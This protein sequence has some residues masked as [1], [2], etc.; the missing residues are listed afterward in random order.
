MNHEEIT[1]LMRQWFDN[2]NQH[3]DIRSERNEMM[4]TYKCESEGANSTTCIDRLKEQPYSQEDV[5][6]C[7]I[8]AKR[9]SY[10]KRLQKL[11]RTNAGIL[12]KVRSRIYKN[13]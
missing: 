3:S 7:S 4:N 1:G 9:H 2:K 11:S 12:N 6:L 13:G 8:C 10:Y 5:T